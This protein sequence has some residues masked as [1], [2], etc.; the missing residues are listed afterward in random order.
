MLISE[1]RFSQPPRDLRYLSSHLSVLDLAPPAGLT[2]CGEPIPL[3]KPHVRKKLEKELN[4]LL[5]YPEGTR[6]TLKRAHR[7]RETFTQIMAREEIP[8]D[9]F[10]LAVAESNLANRT[11]HAG[12]QGF[13][14]FM[15]PAAR[16]YGLE[17]SETVD[18]RFH[19]EKATR[20][21]CHYLRDAYEVF[22]DWTMA[23]ASYNMGTTGLSRSAERQ[24]AD[25]YFEMEDLNAETSRYL[26]RILAYKILCE[27]PDRYGITLQ[28]ANLYEP[29][30]YVSRPVRDDVAD[31]EALAAAQGVSLASLRMLNPWLTSNRL[32]AAEGKTY[33]IRFPLSKELFAHELLVEVPTDTLPVSKASLEL[34]PTEEAETI[35]STDA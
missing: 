34:L 9:M 20:A 30:P 5:R 21:A 23:A 13:W 29:I 28:Q 35:P 27:Q 4:L 31:L 19:P 14:Q 24:Q 17:V 32:D 18:E 11:S 2:F 3:D 10:Y 25:S 16:R 8:Q 1:T 26:Y 6:L 7:Y 15:A 12:A 22:G 33:E